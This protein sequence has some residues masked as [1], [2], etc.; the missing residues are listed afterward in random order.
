[1]Q[2]SSTLALNAHKLSFEQEANNGDGRPM[3]FSIGFAIARLRR[4]GGKK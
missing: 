4:I 2:C 3:I 1:M